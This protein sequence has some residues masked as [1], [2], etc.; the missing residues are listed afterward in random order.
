M[1][2]L[3][4][5]LLLAAASPLAAQRV[6]VGAQLAAAN[7][8]E[9]GSTL[10][11]TGGGGTLHA[12]TSWRRYELELG[13]TR[14]GLDPEDAEAGTESFDMTQLDVRI[15]ARVSRIASVEVGAIDRDMSPSRAA[16]S[17][18]S[19]RLGALLHLPL[20]VGTDLVV[21]SSWLGASRFSGGGSA[22]FGVELGL[23]V[24]YGPGSGRYR[25]TGEYEFQRFD[26]RTDA[27]G[28]RLN[29]PIQ[30]GIAR[31]GVA[32]YF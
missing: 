17:V 26:R 31:L 29:A 30:S 12:S 16:Q 6:T 9:Q 7:Y 8:T 3:S 25:A 28:E 1:R 11:F 4:F 24:S 18:G 14:L 19:L 10:R 20:A 23:G 5:L 27:E 21:R 15:R 13:Y 22:P 32:A 2:P